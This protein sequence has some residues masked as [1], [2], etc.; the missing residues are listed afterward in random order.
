MEKKPLTIGGIVKCPFCGAEY[1]VSEI[2]FPGELLGKPKVNGII[3]DPLGKI[4]YID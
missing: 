4:I 1:H 3:K 2:A